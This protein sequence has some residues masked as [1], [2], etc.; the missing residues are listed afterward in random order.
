MI[1]AEIRRQMNV[2]TGDHVVLS[3]YDGELHITTRKHTLEQVQALVKA[4][5]AGKSLSDELL[6]ERKT[7][8][9]GE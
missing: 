4:H 1:P 5:V 7:A 3:Y 8:A 6:A 9:D 2:K